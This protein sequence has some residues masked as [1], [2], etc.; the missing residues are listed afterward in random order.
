[1]FTVVTLSSISK[2]GL[3]SQRIE[4]Q[5][6]SG[7]YI[8]TNNSRSSNRFPG[9]PFRLNDSNTQACHPNHLDII[10][11]IADGGCFGLIQASAA[12]YP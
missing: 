3:D 9:A 6:Q 12:L 4:E 5:I 8:M 2:R 7:R 10:S 11:A 1:V